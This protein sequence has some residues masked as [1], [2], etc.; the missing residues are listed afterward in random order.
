MVCYHPMTGYRSASLN[1]NGKYPIIFSRRYSY[2]DL[3]GIPLP[4][5]QCVGC[6]LE[7]S[8]QWAIRCVHEASMHKDNA[9]ITLTYDNEHLPE[10][11]S[12]D[13]RHFQLF[14]KRLRKSY[15]AD[16]RFYMAGEYGD[17]Y[18]RPHY[19]ACMFNFDLPDKRL[20]KI[21]RNNNLYTSESLSQIWGKGYTTVGGVTFQSAAYVARYIMKKVTGPRADDYYEFINPNTGEVTKRKPEFTNMSRRPGIGLNWFDKY[22][23]DV[24]PSDFVVLN[25]K[26]FTPPK[27]YTAKYELLYPDEVD[28]IKADRRSRAR[29]RSKDNTPYRLRVREQVQNSR[30]TKLKRTLQ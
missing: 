2:Q 12:L 13:Y 8:R 10:D 1:D 29:L 11:A 17:T 20:L 19:H 18:G 25:G 30:L 26:K 22:Q 16:I 5:G 7:R 9:F 24:F 28:R 14:M 21:E 15:G 23:S 27:A 4:C 6:R 3:P